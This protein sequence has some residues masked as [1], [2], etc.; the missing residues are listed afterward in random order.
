LADRVDLFEISSLFE[1][2]YSS[3]QGTETESL[4]WL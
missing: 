1:G 2:P 3:L 4:G